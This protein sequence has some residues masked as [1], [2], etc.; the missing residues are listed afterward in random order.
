MTAAVTRRDFMARIVGIGAALASGAGGLAGQTGQRAPSR[1]GRAP[2]DTITVVDSANLFAMDQGAAKPVRLPPK[3][4]AAPS[5]TSDAR[6]DLEHH[7]RCQCGCT[8]DVYTCRTT[9]FSCQVSPAMHRDIMALVEGGYGAQE[10]VDAFVSA[11]GERALMAPKKSGFNLVGW[12]TPGVALIGGGIAV[13]VLLHRW[14]RN[15]A[16]RSSAPVTDALD[17][18]PEEIARVEAAVRGDHDG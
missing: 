3:R 16:R 15:A 9:D 11:Y 10:I 5:M 17:A 14:D 12:I 1:S 8:L 18:T 2:G 6:D 4:D 7:I 13:A